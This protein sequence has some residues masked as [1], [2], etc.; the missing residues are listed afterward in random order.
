MSK[1][2]ETKSAPNEFIKEKM[3]EAG[4][5]NLKREQ[6]SMEDSQGVA[7]FSGSGVNAPGN[8]DHKKRD[9]NMNQKNF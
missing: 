4:K 6:E 2:K 9:S 7:D 1:D 3:K 5:N 8:V